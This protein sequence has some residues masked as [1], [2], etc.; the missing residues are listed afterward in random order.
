MHLSRYF[1]RSCLKIVEKRSTFGWTP[2]Y[3][4]LNPLRIHWSSVDSAENWTLRK[5]PDIDIV[6]RVKRDHAFKMKLPRFRKMNLGHVLPYAAVNFRSTKSG[7]ARDT[8]AITTRSKRFSGCF[9]C[10]WWKRDWICP[11]EIICFCCLYVFSDFIN[12][13]LMYHTDVLLQIN[14]IRK[15]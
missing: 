9:H 1:E 14:L 4:R 3:F 10:G 6:N 8:R 7:A 2:I 11:G 15:I 12:I 13:F 5:Q